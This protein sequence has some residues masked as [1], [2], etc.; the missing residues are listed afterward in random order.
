[1][2]LILAVV[3]FIVFKLIGLVFQFALIAALAG[4]IVG[5][6]IGL[7]LRRSSS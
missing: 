4:L 2:A 7:A 5:Y 3:A 1:M 6:G